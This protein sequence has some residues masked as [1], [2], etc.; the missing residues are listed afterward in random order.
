MTPSHTVLVLLPVYNGARYLS[1]QIESVMAQQ[2]SPALA[3]NV[4]VR[5][6]CRDDMST[7]NS[8]AVLQ[9]YARRYP[10]AITLLADDAGNLGAAGNF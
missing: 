6:L 8:R 3:G 5:L 1:E 4:C 10:D 9:D 2:W 7:D